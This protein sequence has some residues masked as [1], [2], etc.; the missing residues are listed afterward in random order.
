MKNWGDHF[1]H[2]K[3][4][5]FND[6]R[7]NS[8]TPLESQSQKMPGAQNA[9]LSKAVGTVSARSKAGADGGNVSSSRPTDVT[10]P[11]V[12]TLC[13]CMAPAHGQADAWHRWRPPLPFPR[14]QP[15]WLSHPDVRGWA[16]RESQHLPRE[17]FRTAPSDRWDETDPLSTQRQYRCMDS[18]LGTLMCDRPGVGVL[19]APFYAAPRGRQYHVW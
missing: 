4:L 16:W 14:P 17:V 13:I 10:L 12:K 5:I 7:Q 1:L 19:V 9:L 8:S 3:R 18:T 2:Q 15:T 11:P 6:L